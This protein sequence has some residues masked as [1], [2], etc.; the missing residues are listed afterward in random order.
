MENLIR[1]LEDT[2]HIRITEE[3]LLITASVYNT[4]RQLMA[5]LNALRK[6]TPAPLTGTEYMHIALTGMSI[7]REVFNEKLE[8]FLPEIENRKVSENHLP[9]LLI[10][11]GACDSPGSLSSSKAGGQASWRTAYVSGFGIIWGPSI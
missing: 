3:D 9:R 8:T 2:F 11:G 6:R 5:R 4:T 1:H 7:P 10:L